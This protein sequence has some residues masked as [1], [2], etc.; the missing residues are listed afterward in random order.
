MSDDGSEDHENHVY[1][2]IGVTTSQQMWIQ[3]NELLRD[4]NIYDEI[5]RLFESEMMLGVY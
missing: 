1:G 2:N 4:H 3:E 5:A